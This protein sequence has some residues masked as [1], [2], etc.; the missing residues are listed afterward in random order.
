MPAGHGATPAWAFGGA[1]PGGAGAVP[2]G[3]WPR[4]WGADGKALQSRSAEEAWV[5]ECRNGRVD[6]CEDGCK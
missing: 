2:S 6:G 5:R 4:F 1:S 3:N